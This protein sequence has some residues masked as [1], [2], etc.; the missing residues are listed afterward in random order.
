M[1]TQ[2]LYVGNIKVS[3][4]GIKYSWQLTTVE[5]TFRLMVNQWLKWVYSSKTGF[6]WQSRISNQLQIYQWWLSK[7]R[8][9]FYSMR[10][11][12]IHRILWTYYFQQFFMLFWIF[13]VFRMTY[14]M[15]FRQANIDK[16][17]ILPAAYI[18]AGWKDAQSW[19]LYV[20]HFLLHLLFTTVYQRFK[21][22][23]EYTLHLRC[24]VYGLSI[25]PLFAILS[26]GE[27]LQ[28]NLK[29]WIAYF[30]ALWF[31]NSTFVESFTYKQNTIR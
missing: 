7:T 16:Y 28:Y 9:G 1:C 6:T 21:L 25:W 5:P 22:K 19:A 31:F 26:K 10:I 11:A 3:F 13:T 17:I 23:V 24:L 29:S 30:F 18:Q 14:G 4:S 20:L 27:N 2:R 12:C 15:F 8:V